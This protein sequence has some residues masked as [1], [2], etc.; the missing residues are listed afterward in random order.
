VTRHDAEASVRAGFCGRELSELW[1][2]SD[3]WVLTERAAWPFSHLFVAR[4]D[5]PL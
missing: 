2:K 4:R 3:A 1:P 5:G